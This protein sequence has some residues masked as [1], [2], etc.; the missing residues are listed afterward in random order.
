MSFGNEKYNRVTKFISLTLYKADGNALALSLTV[1]IGFLM[2]VN[3]ELL[4]YQVHCRSFLY[5]ED[6][7]ES[8]DALRR[9]FAKAFE[10]QYKSADFAKTPFKSKVA[11]IL[12][13]LSR[14][15]L[16]RQKP[17]EDKRGFES[18]RT[19]VNYI[20]SHYTE[21]ITLGDLA[22]ET[23]LS[24]T[25]ISR[26]FTKHFGISFTDYVTLLRLLD[27]EKQMHGNGTLA[28]IAYESG[29]PNV[30]AMI[31]AFKQHRGIT[32][33]NI[34]KGYCRMKAEFNHMW[35]KEGKM[36]EKSFPL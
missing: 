8:F 15:F 30:N 17:V 12:E 16:N 27:A 5:E 23:F 36:Q 2:S 26:C 6:K 3:P 9:D 19:A 24:K 1:S 33:G 25:Y 29:F 18:L 7:Q 14:Y 22:A 21:N 4:K 10:E 35:I 32:P 11:A 34:G 20:Q 28:D 31:H 13:D